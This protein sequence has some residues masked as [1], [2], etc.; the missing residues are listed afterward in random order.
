V[1][2]FVREPDNAYD[3]NAIRAEVMGHRVGYLRRHLAE[4][5]APALD[6]GR[7]TDFEVPGLLRG[8]STRARNVGCHVWLNRC[9]RPRGLNI[10]LPPEEPEWRVSWPI[11]DWE[12][13]S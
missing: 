12:R 11:H 4:Q 7:C 3:R 10:E 1:V 8:G 13:P 5:L 9:L 2:R 6:R